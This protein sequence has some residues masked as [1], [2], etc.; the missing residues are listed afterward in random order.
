MCKA[1]VFESSFLTTVNSIVLKSTDQKSTDI[2]LGQME[3]LMGP[4][5]LKFL[6]TSKLQVGTLDVMM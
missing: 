6:S 1:Y 5:R 3:S 2:N 4:F